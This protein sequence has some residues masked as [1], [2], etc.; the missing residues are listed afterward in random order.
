VEDGEEAAGDRD[1]T[2]SASRN[3]SGS[4]LLAILA[5]G[6]P[7]SGGSRSTLRCAPA[8]IPGVSD[9]AL[10]TPPNRM[11]LRFGRRSISIPR[12]IGILLLAT[13]AGAV[14]GAIGAAFHRG[15][16]PEH[17]LSL[18]AFATPM[19]MSFVLWVAFSIYWE[20]AANNSS[21]TK[22]SE[23]KP[24]RL[25]HLTFVNGAMLIAYWPFAGWPRPEGFGFEFPRILPPAPF[26]VPAGL[27]L[28]VGA[29]LL[30]IWARR[31]LGKNWSGAVTV[32]VDH[33]LVRS[34]P[35][36]RIRHPIYTGVIG[37]YVGTL[38][39][40]GRLQGL[41]ALALVSIAYLRKIRMEERN[42][43]GEFGPTFEAYC[44][45]SWALIPWV[46]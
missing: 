23:S 13:F 20:I 33:E 45:E 6:M 12:R 1:R 46:I 42:L 41:I 27:T 31:H 29:L 34:G 7:I 37:M 3:G 10:P 5:P 2:L 14:A 32:K 17:P 38:L 26:L 22:A 21:A 44:R 19:G 35:Y 4:V 24:S 25:L 18:E 28:Q 40:S 39:I 9:A 43:L 36:K 30:A 16:K 11:V 8:T 15:P